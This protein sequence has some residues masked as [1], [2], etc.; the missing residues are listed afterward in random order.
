MTKH[1]LVV[2]DEK[3]LTVLVK[4]SLEGLGKDYEVTAVTTAEDGF[5]ALKRKPV[6]LVITDFNLP[7]LNGLDLIR[8]LRRLTPQTYTIV[9]TAFST[10]TIEKDALRLGALH[11][12]EKPFNVD[13]LV[14]MVKEIFTTSPK[15]PT[16][17]DP[18]A[19]APSTASSMVSQRTAKVQT[20]L[21]QRGDEFD[22]PVLVVDDNEHN[23]KLLRTLLEAQGSHVHVA[24]NGREAI[25]MAEQYQP[26]LIILDILM[27]VMD[28]YEAARI[29]RQQESTKTIPILMLTA[30]QHVDDKVKGLEAGADDFL[31]KPF[32]AVELLARARSLLRTKKMQDQ[33]EDKAAQLERVLHHYVGTTATEEI[34]HSP[35]DDERA[36]S[37]YVTASVVYADIRGFTNFTEHHHAGEVVAVLN[38]IFEQLADPVIKFQGVLD[39]YIGDALMA[40]FLEKEG[41]QT[42]AYR[43]AQCAITML[44][45]FAVEKMQN[46]ALER[47]GLGI[48]ISTGQAI[49]GSVGATQQMDYTII[50]RVPNLA[51]RLQAQAQPGQ[52]LLDHQTYL[53]IKEQY[54]IRMIPAI[55][56]RGLPHKIQVYELLR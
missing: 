19:N 48:G 54:L 27:P 42:M 41:A 24:H 15:L 40:F 17:T 49:V 10:A 34:L 12:I 5:R 33:L 28:G 9:M 38:S 55:T 36:E 46:P 13:E 26:S 35:E 3:S 51:E 20:I 23:L 2:D 14:R 32:Q 39:K 6:D 52:I 47:L 4:E 37:K 16:V 29:L 45:N 21:A 53:R 22:A 8:K 11:F 56:S 31:S 25:Q 43:A 30:L 44:R 7:G 50:G 1:I 18:I